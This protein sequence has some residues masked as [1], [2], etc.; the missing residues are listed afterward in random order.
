MPDRTVMDQESFDF[1]R[2]AE[3]GLWTDLGKGLCPV[4]AQERPLQGR[5][6]PRSPASRKNHHILVRCSRGCTHDGAFEL[7]KQHF[8]ELLARLNERA[9]SPKRAKR[10]RFSDHAVFVRFG[11][12]CIYCEGDAYA[13]RHKLEILES[14]REEGLLNPTAITSRHDEF[15][16]IQD[17][18]TVMDPLTTMNLFQL[19][20]EHF[21]PVWLQELPDIDLTGE[22]RVRCES[23]WIAPAHGSCNS[24]R[25]K[26][27]EPYDKLLL[28]YSR[29]MFPTVQGSSIE[30]LQDLRI[31][32]SVLD[33]IER[34]RVA[35][36]S[37]RIEPLRRA[38]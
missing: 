19:T 1:V 27:L 10:Y 29:Y 37:D 12:C 24:K 21:I 22:E 33:K 31:F 3:R 18:S 6:M 13:R 25:L 32:Q 35:M 15:G 2:E 4:C 23:V 8:P 28:L 7:Y 11:W 14:M 30:R 16:L 17:V 26:Q 36:G 5:Y 38:T 34:Y 9:A 20:A